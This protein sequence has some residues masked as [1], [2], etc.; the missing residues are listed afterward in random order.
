MV[1][2]PIHRLQAI[3]KWKVQFC[4]AFYSE[5]TLTTFY[6]KKDVM[7]IISNNDIQGTRNA[8]LRGGCLDKFNK[9]M[10]VAGSM[11]LYRYNL[12]LQ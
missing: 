9:C 8:Y 1:E 6:I 2:N 10:W 3:K 12:N 11:Q 7:V 5:N 4:I